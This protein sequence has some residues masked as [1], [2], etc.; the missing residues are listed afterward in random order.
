MFDPDDPF[1]Y[2]PLQHP[3]AARVVP[4][5][6]WVLNSLTAIA[7]AFFLIETSV[8]Y[9]L[10]ILS[11]LSLIGTGTIWLLRFVLAWICVLAGDI[12]TRD[13]CRHWRRWSVTPLL[14]FCAV[15]LV[16]SEIPRSLR[17][18][19]SVSAMNAAAADALKSPPGTT[20]IRPFGYAGLMPIH[21]VTNLDGTNVVL[22]IRGAGFMS[23]T[24]FGYC[25]AGATIGQAIAPGFYV[26]RAVEPPWYIVVEDE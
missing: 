12:K 15:V 21:R 14:V 23:S 5:H 24:Y 1:T 8:P 26:I 13:I 16:K 19:A 2:G 6:G 18:S 7:A 3:F 25:P 4:G 11:F 10:P 22:E 9:A 17:F 20:T